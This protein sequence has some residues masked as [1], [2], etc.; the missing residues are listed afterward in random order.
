[1]T[2]PGPSDACGAEEAV[3]AASAS[4]WPRG[5]RLAGGN[6]AV[7]TP[8]LQRA[9]EAALL[10]HHLQCYRYAYDAVSLGVVR[11]TLPQ[12]PETRAEDKSWR[13]PPLPRTGRGSMGRPRTETALPSGDGRSVRRCAQMSRNGAM[14]RPALQ[15]RLRGPLFSGN[16]RPRERHPYARP[17][18]G[19]PRGG[20]AAADLWGAFSCV[21]G[22]V[23]SARSRP[24]QRPLHILRL[25]P[26]PPL[27]RPRAPP[28]SQGFTGACVAGTCFGAPLGCR[29]SRPP[30]AIS[31][32]VPPLCNGGAAPLR[33]N[34]SC[35]APG[36]GGGR[37]GRGHSPRPGGPPQPGRAE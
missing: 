21:C 22:H 19:R 17:R 37:P 26:P 14:T 4:G 18:E 7:L 24:C 25:P 5:Q 16:A 30:A 1:M 35:A 15:A 34:R 33:G 29:C 23:R 31:R 11:R 27:Q 36:G 8:A 28:R 2:Y 3:G 9:R 12:G 6:D 13:H 20:G 32:A 10:R